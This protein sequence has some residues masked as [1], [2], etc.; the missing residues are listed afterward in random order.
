MNKVGIVIPDQHFPIHDKKAYSVVLQAIE[1]IKPDTFINLGD[2]GEWTSVNGHR[3]KRRKRPPLEYQLPQ[4]DK[5]IEAVNREIDKMD[6]VLDT[7]NCKERHILA[8]N[9]DEWLDA[10]VEENPYLDQYM[11]REACKWDERG[12]TY[13]RYNE[14]LR[15]GKAQFIHGAYCGN[16]HAKKHCDVYGNLIYGH[17]HDVTRHTATRLDESTSAW[18]MGCLKDRSA[19]KN[20][21]LKGKPHNWGHAFGIITWFKGGEFQLDV[22]DIIKGQANVWGRIIKG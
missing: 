15:I 14:L 1:H 11:F 2:V 17:T 19:E 13:K 5:D 18:S 21:W 8:G 4:I 16:N 3:Y 6:A 22:I 10:F 9:H 12:Y 7:I 20:R